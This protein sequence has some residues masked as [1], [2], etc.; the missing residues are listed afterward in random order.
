[1]MLEVMAL[2]SS[3][4]QFMNSMVNVAEPLGETR[5]S[6]EKVQSLIMVLLYG[7]R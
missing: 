6:A 2:P 5:K 1:M 3:Y 7:T 4:L